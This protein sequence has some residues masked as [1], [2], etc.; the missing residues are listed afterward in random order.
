MASKNQ[1]NS[2]TSKV[3]NFWL[4][5]DDHYCAFSSAA[6]R[7]KNKEKATKCY[8]DMKTLKGVVE[9]FGKKHHKVVPL[10][11]M[12]NNLLPRMTHYIKV[13]EKILLDFENAE[14]YDEELWGSGSDSDSDSDSGSD[15]D[16]DSD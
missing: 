15:S 3:G 6:S 14:D 8:N 2:V 7:T 1:V 10:V 4:V 5:L 16:S 12:W 13:Y 9:H 11:Q